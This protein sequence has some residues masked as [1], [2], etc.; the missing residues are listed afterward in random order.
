VPYDALMGSYSCCRFS[1][2]KYVE[3]SVAV[4]RATRAS[5]N[6]G[7]AVAALLWMKLRLWITAAVRGKTGPVRAAMSVLHRIVAP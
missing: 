6:A 1:G 2:S 4:H 7:A 5:V 3:V